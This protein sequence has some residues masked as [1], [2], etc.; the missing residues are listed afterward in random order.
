MRSQGINELLVQGVAPSKVAGL[1]GHSLT[2][3]QS[4]YKKYRLEDD[5]SVLRDD[6]KKPQ[7]KRNLITTDA[8]L[9]YP[10]EVNPKTG[11]WFDDNDEMDLN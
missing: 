8:D 5:H 10:W 2:M 11:E 6:K 4:I 1:A 3:Q 9:P 7:K